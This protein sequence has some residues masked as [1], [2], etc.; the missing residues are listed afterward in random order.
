MAA[1]IQEFFFNWYPVFGVFFSACL[2]VIF[3]KL[4]R[5]TVGS[6]KP[7]TV[8]ASKT[9]PVLWDEVQGVDAAKD[10]LMDVTEWLR[11][12]WEPHARRGFDYEVSGTS[13]DSMRVV[14][15]APT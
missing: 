10:E 4:M 14:R 8:K 5:T 1:E 11:E 2:V 7:E 3:I 6:T 15:G 13:R 12:R 9:K